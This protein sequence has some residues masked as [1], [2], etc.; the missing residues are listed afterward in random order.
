MGRG[1]MDGG[2]SRSGKGLGGAWE[3]KA[4]PNRRRRNEA[5]RAR[6]GE[7]TQRRWRAAR[8]AT[9]C[10]LAHPRI[11]LKP[12]GAARAAN[13]VGEGPI[14][15]VGGFGAERGR[16]AERAR[17]G[18]AEG[19][20]RGR[21]R[22]QALPFLIVQIARPRRSLSHSFDARRNVP[23][24][25]RTGAPPRRASQSPRRAGRRWRRAQ[26]WRSGAGGRPSAAS[27]RARGRAWRGGP[28]AASLARLLDGSRVNG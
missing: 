9:A 12:R 10:S 11:P 15:V 7:T 13:Y 8:R 16:E 21:G 26:K 27:S 1:W 4:P 3:Q 18:C 25:A 19:G 6:G 17:R 23:A 14:H 2:M 22:K 24:C 20:R 5:V 28:R